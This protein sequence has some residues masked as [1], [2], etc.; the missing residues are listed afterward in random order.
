[1]GR[2]KM[3]GERAPLRQ[4][5]IR[6]CPI[7]KYESGR[8]CASWTEPKGYRGQQF[9]H[10]QVRNG[11]RTSCCLSRSRASIARASELI[12]FCASASVVFDEVSLFVARP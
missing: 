8:T 7:A 12:M 1:M 6:L 3:I 5:Q 10:K 2:A 4:L 11:R 9:A